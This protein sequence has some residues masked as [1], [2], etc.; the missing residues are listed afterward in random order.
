MRVTYRLDPGI[1]RLA[2]CA[3]VLRGGSVHVTHGKWVEVLPRFLTDGAW[4]G[5]FASG[6]LD[7]AH[8]LMGFGAVFYERAVVFC[9]PRHILERLHIVRD[10]S[11]IVL[12]PSLA[13][14]LTVAGCRLDVAHI[15]Y[16]ADLQELIRRPQN[17]VGLLRLDDGRT[18]TL[19]HHRNIE[20]D[21]DLTLRVRPK[22]QPPAFRSFTDYRD[23]VSNGLKALAANASD[24]NRRVRYTPLA[25]VSSGYDSAACAALAVDAGC[26]EAVTFRTAREQPGPHGELGDSGASVA[27]QLGMTVREFDRDA[28]KHID[29]FPEAEFAVCGDLGQ[30][31][32]WSAFSSVFERR[33]VITGDHGDSMWNRLRR[34]SPNQVTN[35]SMGGCSLVEFR[36]RVGFVRVAPAFFTTGSELLLHSI[37]NAPEMK[38]W[39]V[40]GHYDRP[41]ARRIAEE[42]GVR[43]ESFGQRK[44]AVAVL[45]NRD[46]RL[47][48]FMKPESRAAFEQFYQA[49]RGL[50]PPVRQALYSAVFAFRACCGRL[51][52]VLRGSRFLPLPVPRRFRMPPGRSSFLVHWAMRIVQAR[53]S[54]D[55]PDEPPLHAR[56]PVS[57]QPSDN[58][59]LARRE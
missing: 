29:G 20:I 46:E 39:S 48:R 13:F 10:G 12:S 15:T 56:S 41:I 54:G 53:Y 34:P 28:Y 49:H 35:R 21:E 45:L 26:R 47:D 51:T 50:R 58:P 33:L 6:A 14:A 55:S 40:P 57:S 30:D 59:A 43:R 44:K 32:P 36:C 9:T 8:L 18:M 42:K 27:L 11:R 16:Q 1:P 2:W 31:L 24:G 3:E 37:S 23:Y 7:E 17:H 25:T 22:P 52:D 5:D 38:P 4:E 19:A